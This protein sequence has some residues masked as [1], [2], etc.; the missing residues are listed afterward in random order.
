MIRAKC[1][2]CKHAVSWAMYSSRWI[3]AHG[4][5]EKTAKHCECDCREP[6]PNLESH[7]ICGYEFSQGMNYC[8]M[9]G[10]K[11]SLV[12]KEEVGA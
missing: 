7:C 8:P 9:D 12:N 3:H 6:L 4:H 5:K 2:N 11:R 10:S 1:I